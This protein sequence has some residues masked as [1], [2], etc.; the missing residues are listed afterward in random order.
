MVSRLAT[1]GLPCSSKM[2]S[3]PE[4]VTAD[5]IFLTFTRGSSSSSMMPVGRR[6]GLA[7]LRGRVGQ[8]GDPTDRRQDVRLGH[9]ERRA[10]ARVE[11]DGEIPGQLEVLPLVLTDRHPLGLVQ[12]DV[13]GHQHRIGEQGRQSGF[14]S[15]AR[16]LVLELGHPAGL[17]EAGVGAQHPGQLGVFGHVRLDED[18]RS[19]GRSR[20]PASAPR[21]AAYGSAGPPDRDWRPARAG[22]RRRRTHRGCPAA[23]PTAAG[24]PGSCRG[25]ASRRSVG[26]T[27]A[28]A[29]WQT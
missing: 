14:G 2:I 23:A 6:G 11:A 24:H 1:P 21:C 13:G 8:V 3:R 12:Q 4:S 10:V 27:T 22:R 28:R 19:S 7:H 25:A 5:L 26:P 15:P 17:A 16:R 20:R 18:R 29:A 9:P